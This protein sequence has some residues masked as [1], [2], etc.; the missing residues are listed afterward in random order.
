[1]KNPEGDG[2]RAAEVTGNRLMAFTVGL[3]LGLYRKGHWF[4][5]E[6]PTSALSWHLPAVKKLSSLPGVRK[7]RFCQCMYKL[8]IAG[9]S[10]GEYVQKDTT[11]LTNAPL[12]TLCCPCDRQ[13]KHMVLVGKVRVKGQWQ[14]KSALAGAYPP[15][16]SQAWAR[17]A[18]LGLSGL[19]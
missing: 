16:L 6:H 8:S 15:L 19:A 10:Q 3:A 5:F 9:C 17:A 11:I 14:S 12:E 7:V 1:M 2:S 13:H 4:S 18:S